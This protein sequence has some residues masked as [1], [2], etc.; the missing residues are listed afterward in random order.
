MLK[1]KKISV[2]G[3]FVR[4]KLKKRKTLQL[5]GHIGAWKMCVG[6]GGGGGA[7]SVTVLT[8]SGSI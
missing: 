5:Q 3:A 7:S 6:G 2:F 1:Y 4:P 8:T